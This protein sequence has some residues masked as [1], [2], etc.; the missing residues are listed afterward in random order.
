MSEELTKETQA[1]LEEIES[2]ETPEQ[3]KERERLVQRFYELFGERL[4]A[5]V[6]GYPP[7][8]S[9]EYRALLRAA[10]EAKDRAPFDAYLDEYPKGSTIA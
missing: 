2:R 9:E 10:V 7:P 1:Q 5:V 8:E 6:L 3:A 4:P